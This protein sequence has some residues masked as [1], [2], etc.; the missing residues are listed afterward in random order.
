MA[1]ECLGDLAFLNAAAVVG[2]ADHLLAALADLAS[3]GGRTGVNGVFNEFLDHV[4]RALHH[5]S[6]RYFIDRIFAE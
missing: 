5:F 3:D 4:D 6:G 1:L 2:D